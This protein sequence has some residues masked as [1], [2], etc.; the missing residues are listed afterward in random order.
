MCGRVSGSPQDILPN[1]LARNTYFAGKDS[2]TGQKKVHPSEKMLTSSMNG[3]SHFT[4]ANEG[5]ISTHN[6]N[7]NRTGQI[8][9]ESRGH[10]KPTIKP[11]GLHERRESKRESKNTSALNTDRLLM[12]K[13]TKS[14]NSNPKGNPGEVG[15]GITEPPTETKLAIIRKF[16]KRLDD[17]MRKHPSLGSNGIGANRKKGS[18]VS[19]DFNQMSI[20]LTDLGFLS[21]NMAG[22]AAGNVQQQEGN[23]KNELWD[24]LLPKGGVIT[25]RNLFVILLAFLGIRVTMPGIPS[26]D[27]LLARSSQKSSAHFEDPLLDVLYKICE[28]NTTN[29]AS[30]SDPEKSKDEEP[31]RIG[32]FDERGDLYLSEEDVVF[33]RGK[34]NLLSVNYFRNQQRQAYAKARESNCARRGSPLWVRTRETVHTETQ[35]ETSALKSESHKTR[36]VVE[37]LLQQG[38][39]QKETKI[40]ATRQRMNEEMK[41]CSFVPHLVTKNVHKNSDGLISAQQQPVHRTLKLFELAKSHQIEDKQLRK[42]YDRDPIDIDFE[43]NLKHCTF[44][45]NLSTTSKGRRSTSIGNFMSSEPQPQFSKRQ[46]SVSIM[47]HSAREHLQ[48]DRL[49]KASKTATDFTRMMRERGTSLSLAD[50]RRGDNQFT[51]LEPAESRFK[52]P[53]THKRALKGSTPVPRQRKANDE[54]G[55]Q[56]GVLFHS[57]TRKSKSISVTRPRGTIQGQPLPSQPSRHEFSHSFSDG[58]SIPGVPTPGNGRAACKRINQM[59]LEAMISGTDDKVPLLFLDIHLDK[60]GTDRIVVYEG[61]KPY[62]LAAQ[63][64]VKHGTIL[65]Q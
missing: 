31:R 29:N 15:A 64:A 58:F 47:C 48:R 42:K 20:I 6:P 25:K 32:R 12:T 38:K 40:E 63:F 45:P 17:I 30:S 9:H 44:Q 50:I 8:S 1:N 52:K 2:S 37:Y 5:K 46:E 24:I 18:A 19:F 51:H 57:N 7:G 62:E 36:D 3:F 53:P 55:N 4:M 10:S 34:F 16:L 21:G 39:V 13:G 35:P 27:S 14:G 61:S 26:I 65:E 59:N 41:E 60:G 28:R 23:L 22:Q 11:L 56:A 43:R 49:P 33:I 54:Q